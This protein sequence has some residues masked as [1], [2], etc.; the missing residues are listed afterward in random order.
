MQLHGGRGYGLWREWPV[1][2]GVTGCLQL[3]MKVRPML[4]KGERQVEKLG[5]W[6]QLS[7]KTVVTK[8]CKS[9]VEVFLLSL[10]VRIF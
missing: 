6:P 3:E 5:L 2:I 8:I 9:S 10:A 7:R 1:V 4:K